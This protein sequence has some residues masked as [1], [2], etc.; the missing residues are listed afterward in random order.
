MRRAIVLLLPLFCAPAWGEIYKYTDANGNTVYSEHAPAG[1]PSQT[2]KLPPL[3]SVEMPK[4][5]APE[6]TPQPAPQ[7]PPTAV[8]AYAAL[9][10]TGIPPDGA[11]RAN[12]GT[13]DV[14][15]NIQPRLVEGQ[16]LQLLLD[17]V[18]Y[19]TPGN[20]PR[21]Q[22]VNVD[23]GQHSLAVQV[24]DGPRVVQAS[25]PVTIYVMRVSAP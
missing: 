1:Q 8:T 25:P 24:L 14:G 10:L 2:V 9:G 22:L 15:V 16:L 3:N 11:I 7:P 21:L 12:N 18:A 17:G 4:G 13:F 19:G 23:R 5:K 6:P 20:V